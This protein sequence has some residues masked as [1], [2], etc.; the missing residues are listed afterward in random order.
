M[1]FFSRINCKPNECNSK[2]IHIPGDSDL[3]EVKSCF[4]GLGI[5]KT[6][7]IKN[8]KYYGGEDT[9]NEV[10]EHVAFNECIYANGGKLFINPKMINC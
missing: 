10:C 1:I 8:C 6:K 9:D 2:N 7:F 4:G 5:Y 3:I